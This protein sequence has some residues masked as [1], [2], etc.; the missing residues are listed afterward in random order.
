MTAWEKRMQDK[1][2]GRR[3]KS[4]SDKPPPKKP[5]TPEVDEDGLPFDDDDDDGDG[6]VDPCTP[7]ETD[8][9]VLLHGTGNSDPNDFG[10]LPSYKEMLEDEKM[11]WFWGEHDTRLDD[12]PK[13]EEELQH[14]GEEARLEQ[15]QRNELIKKRRDRF[16]EIR[17]ELTAKVCFDQP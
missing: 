17:E 11:T 15:L 5:K 4:T 12:P 14:M 8:E 16:K 6:G 10:P 2:F 9:N 7:M 3:S 1:D 13:E